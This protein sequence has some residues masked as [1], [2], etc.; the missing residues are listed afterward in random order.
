[1]IV[2]VF[3]GLFCVHVLRAFMHLQI[4]RIPKEYILQRYTSL[5]GKMFR[6]Q[7]MIGI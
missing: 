7:E 6:F 4:E 2:I 1:M 3:I 5:Q